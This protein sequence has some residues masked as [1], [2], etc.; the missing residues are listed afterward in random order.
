[1][2]KTVLGLPDE[3]EFL[4]CQFA[5]FQV[6]RLCSNTIGS[7]SPPS[8]PSLSAVTYTPLQ[9]SP[10][11]PTSHLTSRISSRCACSWFGRTDPIGIACTSVLTARML[12]TRSNESVGARTP[13]CN[14][15]KSLCTRCKMVGKSERICHCLLGTD[16]SSAIRC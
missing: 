12:M 6:Q 9:L 15:T 16:L 2:R 5:P 3:Q 14:P 11:P 13:V 10:L 1:M 7:S 8:P 4:F